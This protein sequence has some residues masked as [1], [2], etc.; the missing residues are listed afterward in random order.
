MDEG[1]A[2]AAERYFAAV[3]DADRDL[4]HGI[5]ESL[6]EQGVPVE[7]IIDHVLSPTQRAVGDRWECGDWT[8]AREHIA[9]E[10]SD[11]VLARLIGRVAH[12]RSSERSALIACAEGEWHSLPS[13]GLQLRFLRE[14]WRAEVLGSSVSSSQLA[15]AV[16]DQGPDVVMISCS[17]TANLPG[18]RRMILA[19]REAATP[20]VVGGAAFGK[21]PDRAMRLGANAW[22]RWIADAVDAARSALRPGTIAALPPPPDT[23][24]VALLA[25][26]EPQI[27]AGLSGALASN[28]DS[29]GETAAGGVWTLRSLHA[30]LLCEEPDIVVE[31]LRWQQRRAVLGRALPAETVVG[32]LMVALPAE[33]V[34]ARTVLQAALARVTEGR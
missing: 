15:T 2:Q 31:Q 4:A 13:R 22:A 20:V 34:E 29:D 6:E 28:E 33:A 3:A 12:T 10:I 18:A 30:A 8:V 24:D 17:M 7:S 1:L 16:Y 23:T 27:I 25:S 26:K 11:H 19:A 5:I 32:A 14:G 21:S 9:T